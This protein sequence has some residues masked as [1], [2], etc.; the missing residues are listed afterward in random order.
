MSDQPQAPQPQYGPPGYPVPVYLPPYSALAIISFVFS[1]LWL[2]GVGSLVGVVLGPLGIRECEREGKRGKG[3]A[4]A[5]TVIGGI[6]TAF[7]A[8]W[9]IVLV[10]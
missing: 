4:I 7:L 1:L 5:G 10:V 3:L 9:L 2:C 6:G 8:V